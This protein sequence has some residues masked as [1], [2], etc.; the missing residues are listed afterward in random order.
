M[1]NTIPWARPEFWGKEQEYVL[2]ALQSTWIS[3]GEYVDR[4][5]QQFATRFGVS[6]ALTAANGT[7]SLHMA[8]LA[9]GIQPGDELVLPGFAFLAA[10][11]VALHMQ[12]KPIFAEVDSDTWCVTA[13]QIEKC[14]TPRTRAIV[15]VHT[16]GNVCE[17]DDINA[18]AEHAGIPVI[19]D[20]AEALAS[21]YK[22]KPAG[23]M[24]AIGS[25]SFQ[26]TKTI[27]TGE[28]GMV[29]TNRPALHDRM[30]LYRSHG[31]RRK[32]HYWHEMPG[33]NFRLTNLQ[34]ALGCA[35]F[36]ELD[37]IIAA[38][39]GLQERYLQ[40]L[41]KLTGVVP[42]SYSSNVEP[43]LW[44]MA[45]KIDEKAYP[46]GRDAVIQQMAEAGIETRPGFY[47]PSAM[48]FYACPPLPLCEALSRSVLSL[49][50][51]PTLSDAQ[52]HYICDQ[53]R[54]LRR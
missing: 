50:S 36:E 33:Y 20:A 16:Y 47:P 32:R 27:T 44:A 11:N 43:V 26:A 25:F 35:Q 4:L 5:E 9:L 30:A 22:G 18:V 19:E 13:E 29:V 52:I 45:V 39:A 48:S 40:A 1:Q 31:M 51:Y 46:Q 12:A 8:Y 38:R 14:I 53:L 23:T 24:S 37:S 10:A 34:A 54:L 7:A 3:G 41:Q 49:P 15:P 6:H 42:Q 2:D 28:G 21:R 17:M